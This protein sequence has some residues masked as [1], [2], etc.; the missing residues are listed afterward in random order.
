MTRLQLARRALIGAT[1]PSLPGIARA[2]LPTLRVADQRGGLRSLLEAS[3]QARDLPYRIDWSEFPAAQPLLEALNANTVDV[4]SM[5]DL[6]VFSSAA[7]QALVVKDAEPLKTVADLRGK[8]IAAARG[9]WTHYL[10]L[11]I[12]DHGGIAPAEIRIAWLLP[13]EAGLAFRSGEIDAWSVWELAPRRAYEIE[14]TVPAVPD[15]AIVAEVRAAAR[16]AVE[17][18]LLQREVDATRALD[19][20]FAAAVG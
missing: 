11:R 8:R 10:L 2:R 6:N 17:F 16:K 19:L 18:G 5:G 9:G 3:G 4:G 15:A 14:A 12:L 13:A 20:S 1:A 7:S